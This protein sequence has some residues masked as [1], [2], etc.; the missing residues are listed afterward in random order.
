MS[1]SVWIDGE[2]CRELPLA[3]PGWPFA[4]GVFRT[5]LVHQGEIQDMAGQIAHL[6][7][8]GERLGLHAPDA[9][10][11]TWLTLAAE[12]CGRGR[13][14]MMLLRAAGGAGYQSVEAPARCWVDLQPLPKPL[15]AEPLKLVV[16]PIRLAEQPALAGIKHLNR[17][18]QV[19]AARAAADSA[20]EQLLCDG[21]G[22][23]ISTGRANLFWVR[24]GALHTPALDRCGIAG[25]TRAR[26]IELAAA[27]DI[28]LHQG[29][30]PLASLLAAEEVFVCNSLIGIRP[31]ADC[32]GREVT[33][34]GPV[35]GRLI[36]QL[37]HP[38]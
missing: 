21:A 24:D 10:W 23:P 13:L 15:N 35:T 3:L 20:S 4:D 16:S 9:D 34:P 11:P 19:L 37:K 14:R 28:A 22:R 2:R 12:G 38:M 32:L 31:V 33:A 6:Q 29:D 17:L 5:L 7:A 1:L 25:R 8:D 26:I 30:W 27:N 18:E 36:R